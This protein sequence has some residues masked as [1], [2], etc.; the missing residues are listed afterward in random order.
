MGVVQRRTVKMGKNKNKK[1]NESK[2]INK[3]PSAEPL[4]NF[5]PIV[6]CFYCDIVSFD[7]NDQENYADHLKKAHNIN[8][9]IQPLL[10]A[11]LKLQSD[12]KTFPEETRTEDDNGNTKSLQEDAGNV[13]ESKSNATLVHD[14]KL[15]CPNVP[16]ED[17][18]NELL[19]EN[20]C[21][22]TDKIAS[23]P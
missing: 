3:E 22:N 20:K 10:E 14:T 18:Q 5:V 19:K 15:E 11:T 17:I 7:V 12:I 9:N 6:S 2:V 23:K 21:P 1:L 8:K 4:T 16:V 13:S